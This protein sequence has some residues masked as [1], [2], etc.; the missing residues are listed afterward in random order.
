MNQSNMWAGEGWEGWE[1]GKG[2]E[3]G[4]GWEEVEKCE[5]VKGWEAVEGWEAGEGWE[6]AH[7]CLPTL[8]TAGRGLVTIA[9]SSTLLQ[10]SAGVTEKGPH[11]DGCVR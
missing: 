11:K 3:A 10:L 5:A 8:T 1:A 4:E 2:W 9:V 6:A 7:R